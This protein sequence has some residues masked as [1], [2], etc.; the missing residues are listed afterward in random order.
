MRKKVSVIGAGN[1]G[2]SAAQLVA[3]ASLADVVLLILQTEFLRER[4]SIL[5]RHV[6]SGILLFP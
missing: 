3:Q 6:P 5:Q 4:P 1:V 2:A